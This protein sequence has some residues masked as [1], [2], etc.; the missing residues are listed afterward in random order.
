VAHTYNPSL[1]GSRHQ[2]DHDLKPARANSL[3]D[4][5]SKQSIAEKKEGWWSSSSDKSTC[6]ASLDFKPQCCQKKKKN[7]L[8]DQAWVKYMTHTCFLYRL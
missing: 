3:R 2:E 1:S 4:L 5:I 8:I 7:P 6:L